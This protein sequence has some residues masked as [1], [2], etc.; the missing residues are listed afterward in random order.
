MSG[1]NYGPIKYLCNKVLYANNGRTTAE[2]MKEYEA[3]LHRVTDPTTYA[4]Y[5]ISSYDVFVDETQVY[6]DIRRAFPSL[7]FQQVC[8]LIADH[9]GEN[10]Q[11]NGIAAA[12]VPDCVILASSDE[13]TREKFRERHEKFYK[14]SSYWHGD[15]VNENRERD[16]RNRYD[17][18]S[19]ALHF[20]LSHELYY[21]WAEDRAADCLARVREVYPEATAEQLQEIFEKYR[22]NVRNLYE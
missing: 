22:V 7:T 21:T 20:L 16:L 18:E 2:N 9:M 1:L 19:L 15:Q 11:G 13:Y 5:L 6:C 12:L 8:K 3:N 4:A 17:L 14:L 10:Q